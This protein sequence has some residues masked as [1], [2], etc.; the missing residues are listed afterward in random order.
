VAREEV[1]KTMLKILASH[2]ASNFHFLLTGDESWLL[3]AYHI[4][5]IWTLSPENINQV[6]RPS[7]FA[8]ET[9]A[10]V[11]FNG[12]GLHMIDILPQNQRMDAEYFAE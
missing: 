3:Y 4:R 5:T 9:M 12:T 7:H 1:A 2:A 10:I 6:Q 11:F 8:K